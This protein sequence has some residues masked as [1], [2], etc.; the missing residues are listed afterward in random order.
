MEHQCT[1]EEFLSCI[2]NHEIKVI[3]ED[4]V[5]RHIRFKNPGTNNQ[6]FDLITWPGMLCYTGDMGTYVFQRTEDMFQFFRDR[7]G[8]LSINPGYWGEKL[9]AI[10]G[11][12]GFKKFS[13]ETFRED[14][15]E[16]LKGYELEKDE[17]AVV[18]EK[19]NDLVFNELDGDF[20]EPQRAYRAIQNQDFG[21]RVCFSDFL[22]DCSVDE[23]TY[24]FIWALY[25]IAW[26]VIQYD[27]HESPV[28]V[29]A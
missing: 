5:Y 22:C 15:I 12:R 14:V 23:Y 1:V 16:Y 9:Q 25:A 10:D 28:V 2:N 7:E 27:K 4:G 29:G 17:E 8:E 21:R 19:L 20:D 13:A 6:Y 18:M 3:R 11:N 24:S 26:G